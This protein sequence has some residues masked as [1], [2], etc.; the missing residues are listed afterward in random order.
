MGSCMSYWYN[1]RTK[2]VETDENRGP[3]ADILGPF[4]S[5]ELAAGAIESARRREEHEN[6]SDA[7]WDG[8]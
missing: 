1:V 3:A 2:E 5:H 6:A 7:R 4:D 8:D